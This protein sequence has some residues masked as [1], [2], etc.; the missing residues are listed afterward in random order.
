MT[1]GPRR[2]VQITSRKAPQSTR[3]SAPELMIVLSISLIALRRVRR[4]V[5]SFERKVEGDVMS[6]HHDVCD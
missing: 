6:G 5:R 3:V 1:P 4:N 2:N